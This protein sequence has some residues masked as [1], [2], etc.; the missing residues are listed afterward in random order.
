MEQAKQFVLYIVQ[1]LVDNQDEV[2]VDVREDELGVLIT[3]K[4]AQDD[5]G[6]I[7]GKAGNTVQAIRNLLKVLGKK[8][9][10]RINLKVEEPPQ[11]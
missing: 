8:L 9:N 11:V 4:V 1:S 7:I 2:V 3:V 5:M 10:L 6:K